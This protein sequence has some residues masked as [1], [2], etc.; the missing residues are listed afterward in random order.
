[1]PSIARGL[2]SVGQRLSNVAAARLPPAPKQV[3]PKYRD[4]AH[5]E[6]AAAVRRR[7]A[8]RCQGCGREGTRLFADHVVELRDGG[9]PFDPA[10]GQAL[11]GSCHSAK[12]ARARAARHRGPAA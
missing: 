1:M 12:T 9:A 6:W 3:D 8:G 5:E 2:R 10:N 7:A 11:C 4:P